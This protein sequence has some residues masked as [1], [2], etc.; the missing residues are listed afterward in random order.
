[1][2]LHLPTGGFANASVGFFLFDKVDAVGKDHL[3]I[4]LAIKP[5]SSCDPDNN[6]DHKNNRQD[7]ADKLNHDHN[8]TPFI[9]SSNVILSAFN[10][11]LM[12]YIVGRYLSDSQSY[13]HDG[14]TLAF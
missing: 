6:A 13:M 14:L 9:K 3:E 8:F 12:L 2:F 7:H 1:M 10:N 5:A 4:V 11:P